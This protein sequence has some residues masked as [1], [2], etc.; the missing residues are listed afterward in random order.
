MNRF[1]TLLLLVLTITI[2]LP[3]FSADKIDS[4]IRFNDLYGE[5]KIKPNA[6]EDSPYE[7]A[8]LDTI[9]YEDDRIKTE[10]DSGAILGL[11]D[12]STYVIK[13]ES[14]LIIH[15]EENNVSKIEILAGT[16]WGNLKKMSEGKSLEIEMSQ[17]VCGMNGSTVKFEIRVLDNKLRVDHIVVIKGSCDIMDMIKN[18]VYHLTVGQEATV[19]GK[20]VKIIDAAVEEAQ[21]E[22]GD[23]LDKSNEKKGFEPLIDQLNKQTEDVINTKET[24]LDSTIDLINKNV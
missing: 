21:K 7:F 14:E 5:V 3:A 19:D 22:L 16:M 8:E 10:E 23:I 2:A 24:I 4:K 18:E 17:C 15:T 6:D 11:E 13:P 12:M 20:G 9:I 1:K